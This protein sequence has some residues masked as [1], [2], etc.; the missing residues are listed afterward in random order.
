MDFVIIISLE[1]LALL[2]YFFVVLTLVRL[3]IRI[4][5]CE[6]LLVLEDHF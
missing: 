4:L 1:L 3:L 6:L 5:L 2:K